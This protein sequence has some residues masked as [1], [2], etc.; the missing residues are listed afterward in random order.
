[1]GA[2][3]GRGPHEGLG[4]SECWQP[5]A[6]QPEPPS[7]EAV[8][9]HAVGGSRPAGFRCWSG[10]RCLVIPVGRAACGFWSERKVFP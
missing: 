1:M 8:Q 10:L 4:A 9:A 5:G 7:R 3:G 2:G 6:M